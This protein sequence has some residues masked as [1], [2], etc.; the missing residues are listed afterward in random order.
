MRSCPPVWRCTSILVVDDGYYISALWSVVADFNSI[1]EPTIEDKRSADKDNMVK[2][3]HLW[4]GYWSLSL[5]QGNKLLRAQWTRVSPAGLCAP[6]LEDSTGTHAPLLPESLRTI[7][8]RGRGQ[9]LKQ[10]LSGWL[11]V[12]WG[13]DFIKFVCAPFLVLAYVCLVWFPRGERFSGLETAGYWG[14]TPL[15]RVRRWA[16]VR[17]FLALLHPVTVSHHPRRML[18]G[19]LMMPVFPHGLWLQQQFACRAT[20]RHAVALTHTATLTPLFMLE[21]SVI[22]QTWHSRQHKLRFL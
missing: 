20:G 12:K 7:H 3:P 21:C 8:R 19:S 22:I 5:S 15:C 10:K 1:L 14:D 2:L 11:S 9:M 6:G 4:Y 13:K 16:D 18:S 17:V